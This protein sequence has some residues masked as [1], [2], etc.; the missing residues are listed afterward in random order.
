MKLEEQLAEVYFK[1]VE[2]K[3]SPFEREQAYWEY[4]NTLM[5]D[6]F[7]RV[8]IS[9]Y[10]IDLLKKVNK[11]RDEDMKSYGVEK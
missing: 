2:E 5:V 9:I 3:K 10:D 8:F 7:N 11:M 4:Y 1:A 6:K